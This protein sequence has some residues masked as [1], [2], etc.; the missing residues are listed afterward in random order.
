MLSNTFVHIQKSLSFQIG[1]D[2]N[3]I[4]ESEI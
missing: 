3:Y 4:E 1:L 2:D